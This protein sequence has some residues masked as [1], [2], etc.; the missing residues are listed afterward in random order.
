MTSK[1]SRKSDNEKSVAKTKFFINFFKIRFVFSYLIIIM[2]LKVLK[3]SIYFNSHKNFVVILITQ[4]NYSTLA[5]NYVY[6][7]IQGNQYL[8]LQ[9]QITVFGK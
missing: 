7:F 9:L 2:H 8:A 3:S 6:L 5:T 1:K 4:K